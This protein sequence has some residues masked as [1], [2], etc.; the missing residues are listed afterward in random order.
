MSFTDRNI[1]ENG[2]NAP[3]DMGD[4]AFRGLYVQTGLGIRF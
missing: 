2:T 3:A 4:L 1:R